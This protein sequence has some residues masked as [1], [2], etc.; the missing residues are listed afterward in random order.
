[1]IACNKKDETYEPTYVLTSTSNTDNQVV[2]SFIYSS[3]ARL[4]KYIHYNY[5]S[6]GG[7]STLTEN[8]TYDGQGRV[9]TIHAI[10]AHPSSTHEDDYNIVY[11]RDSVRIF[12][13][14]PAKREMVRFG[15]QNGLFSAY[16][17]DL[18]WSNGNMHN[19]ISFS[20][21]GKNVNVITSKYNNTLSAMN[22]E[23]FDVKNPFYDLSSINPF[24]GMFL[25][26]NAPNNGLILPMFSPERLS[27]NAVKSVYGQAPYAYGFYYVI[28]AESR[29][30]L[31][32][33]RVTSFQG[34]ETLDTVLYRYRGL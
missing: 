28:D 13:N 25:E 24:V 21:D 10:Y 29:L 31:H 8:Y 4:A 1:M 20:Y 17:V 18:T 19:D 30:P 9:S 5:A 7:S 14:N 22:I 3:G 33:I 16:K 26:L 12:S 15:I 27:P 6:T 34:R 2:D 11:E 23:Y 32:Q